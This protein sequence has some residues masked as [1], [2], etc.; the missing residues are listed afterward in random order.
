MK[1]FLPIFVL[2]T[3]SACHPAQKTTLY[4]NQAFA[5]YSNK[6]VQGT[7]EATVVSPTQIRSNYQS[8]ANSTFSRLIPF[9]LSI[10]EK[11]N[12]SPSGKN[13]WILIGEEHESP[14]IV[15][16]SSASPQPPKPSTFLPAN[17]EYNFRVDMSPVIKQFNEKG[18]YEAFD[19]TR[20][21]KADFKGFYI[22]GG[23]EPLSWD[24]VNLANKGLQ[25]KDSGKNNIY[26][27][28]IR[29]NPYNAADS[30]D[31]SWTLTKDISMRPRYTS[32]QSI[33]DA[34]FN[35][36]L[37]EAT[38]NIEPD[39]T[40]RT[41]AKWG[42]VWTRD[43]SYSTVLA[44]AYHEPDV[45]KTSLRKKVKRG[46]IIQDTGSGGA[47]PVS[48][49]R[50]T[51]ALAAWEIYKATGDKNWLAEAF[52][53]I[54]NSVADDEKTIYDA[55]TG[56]C[57]GESSFL[58][59]REQTYP[60][61]M[62]NM[63]IYVSDNL[64]T[65]VVHYQT[66]RIL[67]EMA[68]ILGK[69]SEGYQAKA[70]KIKAGIN[71]YLWMPDQGFYAQYRYGRPNKTISPR[72]EALGEALAVIFDVAD[73]AKAASIVSKS[74]VTDFGVT[75]IYPQIPGIPPYHNNGVWPFVQA[76]WN[77]AAAKAGNE[78]VLNHGLAAIYRAGALFLTNYENFVAESG[79]FK[80]TEINSD[81][82]LW[83]M[84]GNLAMVH[85]VFMGMNFEADGIRFQPAIPKTYPG[86]KTLT[87]FR[88]RKAVLNITVNGFGNQI[89]SIRLDGQPLKNAFLLA[90]TIGTHT[91]EIDMQ[92][93]D[94]SQQPIHLVPN[95]FTLP[96]PLARQEGNA[97][98]WEAIEAAVHYKIY[99]NGVFLEKTTA[100]QFEVKADTQ[101]FSEYKVSA[102]DKADNESFTSEPVVFV[103]K[104]AV[105]IFELEE[106]ASKS[107][108][109]YSNYSGKGF[110]EIT[111]EKNRTVTCKINVES[112][113]DY[114]LDIRYSNGSGP[115]NTDNKCAIRSLTVNDAYA[116]VLVF[117]QRGK[118][119]WSDWGFSNA[120]TVRLNKGENTLKLTFEDWNNNMN[121]EVNTAMLD[122]V[123]VVA[124]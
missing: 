118:D 10:N 116:G 9:K 26:T 22:A 19:G 105:K 103:D 6:V 95:V 91:V 41:G 107:G 1:K 12:E 36:S 72:F 120:R 111:T 33:V 96:N 39:S 88:Y 97:L 8:P 74:P 59:W 38:K 62:S 104:S 56:L 79:D 84:A 54:S 53:V 70:E 114:L 93:N 68:K 77:L 71:Q 27:L 32:D 49:D 115:W 18:Y 7:N 66:N 75:C 35:L 73:P 24:F 50:T 58:D 65:N 67:A 94:F 122:Y 48:S 76:Y 124:R 106:V 99:K 123:R 119:E 82:M 15:F 100:A 37:E 78:Q 46:R 85:R 87:N 42:G 17:Y 29:F 28:T 21:A 69:P 98:K 102:V 117:A 23:A 63:D 4:R 11:D 64:G 43:V 47:W 92:N 61:W 60:K 81:R 2:V 13:H 89:K 55:Q 44:F 80:G 5:V 14:V 52:Q 113:G 86:K 90:A 101:K 109:P 45:A 16:G 3:L 112:A 57:S 121:V 51:W 83:S 108:L 34:L 40:F 110:I 25:L 30:K 31:K 20:V